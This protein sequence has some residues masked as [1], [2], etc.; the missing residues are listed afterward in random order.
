MKQPGTT[1]VDAQGIGLHEG[2]RVYTYD[3]F[4][5]NK[6]FYGTLYKNEDYPEVSEY[7]VEYDDGKECAVLDFN[8]I[9]KA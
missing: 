3:A 4:G 8:Q 5:G 2:N 6:R 7:Y 1:I 9:W